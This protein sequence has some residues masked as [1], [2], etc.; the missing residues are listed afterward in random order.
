MQGRGMPCLPNPASSR[1]CHRQL[2][3]PSGVAIATR[4]R[5]DTVNDSH[6]HNLGDNLCSVAENK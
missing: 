4:R 5:R 3:R 2:K 1:D 6:Q